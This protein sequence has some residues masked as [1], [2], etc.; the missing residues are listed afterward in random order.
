MKNLNESISPEEL[1]IFQNE[2]FL[3]ANKPAGIP[4][5]EDL[6]KDISFNKLLEDFINAPLYVVHRLDR[7]ASG[8]IVYAKTRR[9]AAYFSGLLAHNGVQK[10]YLA[11]VEGF[12]KNEE[13]ELIHF[14]IHNATAKK[15]I[16]AKETDK[17]SRLSKLSYKTLAKGTHYTCLEVSLHTG[18]FHQIRSQLA[19]MGHPIKGDVKYGARRSNSD[20]SIHLHAYQLIFPLNNDD[21]FITI[22]AGIPNEALWKAFAEINPLILHSKYEIWKNQK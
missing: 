17:K 9:D 22:T 3:I 2:Y 4:S 11:A 13:D 20:K 15:S 14:L 7:P 18:R 8:I 1:I 5:Q 19:G 16:V 10:T 6:T 21:D 12:P